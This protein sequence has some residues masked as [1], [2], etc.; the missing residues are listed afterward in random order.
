[1]DLQNKRDKWR[2]KMKAYRDMTRGELVE[3]KEVLEQQYK[4]KMALG[5][6]LDMS[7]GKP[8]VAQLDSIMGMQK[9]NA[10]LD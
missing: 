9:H 10:V 8:S 5:L 3:L 1:M 7:R 4:E 6:K 2:N